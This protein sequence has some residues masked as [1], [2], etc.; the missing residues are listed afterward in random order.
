MS[1]RGRIEREEKVAVW[2]AQ[3]EENK[4]L[5][6]WGMW[7]SWC[8]TVVQWLFKIFE[9]GREA[10]ELWT[11]SLPL[12]WF[13]TQGDLTQCFSILCCWE[14]H[15]A[16]VIFLQSLSTHRVLLLCKPC[17]QIYTLSSP[18]SVP[19]SL[20]PAIHPLLGI[21]NWNICKV[22][23]LNHTVQEKLGIPGSYSTVKERQQV[24]TGVSSSCLRVTNGPREMQW[25]QHSWA[26]CCWV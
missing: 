13:H 8:C 16:A 7:Q 15:S 9:A 14:A 11:S 25:Y 18:A 2:T 20:L 1:G 19:P 21:W 22:D 26:W 5:R 24:S 23:S 4:G 6:S 3:E 12:F 17:P 10:A